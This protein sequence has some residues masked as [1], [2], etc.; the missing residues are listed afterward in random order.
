MMAKRGGFTLIELLVVI[1]IIA[2]LAAMLLPALSKAKARAVA[3]R[4]MNS[5]KQLAYAGLMYTGDF[6]EMFPPNPDDYTTL[7]GYTWTTDLEQTTPY[8]SS[9]LKDPLK[10]VI[11]SY[12]G[13]N[14]E[15]FQCPADNRMGPDPSGQSVRAPRSVS[16]NQG[17]GTI[18]PGFWGGGAHSGKPDRATDG[19]WLTG[20]HGVN[21]H[22]NPYA[23]FGK[24]T[25][26]RRIGSCDVF[27]F[28][29][30]NPLSINDGAL[31]VSA[32]A[33]RWIDYPASGHNN[34]CGFSFCDGHAEIHK[35]RTTQLQLTKPPPHDASQAVQGGINDPDW[36]W[37]VQ[38]S[39]I[40][41]Q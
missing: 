38:H 9:I 29:D 25:D 19:P 20:A 3:A 1:A 32:G 7:Q 8:D 30:E 11:A 4:C 15:I 41:V 22:D 36:T 34:A 33:P 18:D 5:S 6:D 27:L 35:W 16:M 26:F 28:V 24:T 31:A 13:G 39:T 37:L 10:T 23:T 40:K 17:V 12:I 21:K 14:V 2:I